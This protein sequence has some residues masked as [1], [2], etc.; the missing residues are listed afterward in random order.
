MNL[1][2]EFSAEEF[3]G[4]DEGDGGV[5][6]IEVTGICWYDSDGE[7]VYEDLPTETRIPLKGVECHDSSTG[8]CLYTRG[9]IEYY[10]ETHFGN[11]HNAS[12]NF[13]D[14]RFI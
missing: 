12:P 7:E 3:G 13:F 8:E 14:Y 6:M 2:Q 10:L 5:E 9:E 1:L 4:G 11:K